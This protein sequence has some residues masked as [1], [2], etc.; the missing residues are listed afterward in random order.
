[1]PQFLIDG[2]DALTEK[3][4]ETHNSSLPRDVGEESDEEGCGDSS[5][6]G[7]P[8]MSPKSNS[9]IHDGEKRNFSSP[10]DI[11]EKSVDETCGDSST[12]VSPPPSPKSNCPSREIPASDTFPSSTGDGAQIASKDRLPATAGSLSGGG[13]GEIPHTLFRR[14]PI[15]G[16]AANVGISTTKAPNQNT[17]TSSRSQ[18]AADEDG[19]PIIPFGKLKVPEE[20]LVIPSGKREALEEESEEKVRSCLQGVSPMGFLINIGFP[21][22]CFGDDENELI[23]FSC[24]EDGERAGVI[25]VD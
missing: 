12:D 24:R 16:V 21:S 11:D 18:P 2:A 19:E 17:S 20:E 15:H 7:S 1:M 25:P 13:T 9:S 14:S 23:H 6:G 3:E 5:V 10:P 22:F 4:P 8:P